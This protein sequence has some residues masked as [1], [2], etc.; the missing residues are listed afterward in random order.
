MYFYADLNVTL[1]Q[2]PL[3]TSVLHCLL[4]NT[5]ITQKESPFLLQGSILDVGSSRFLVIF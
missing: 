5:A 3:L 2:K 4:N 1:K